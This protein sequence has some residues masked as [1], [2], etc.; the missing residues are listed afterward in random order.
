MLQHL[1]ESCFFSS[2]W[3]ILFYLR[4]IKKSQQNKTKNHHPNRTNSWVFVF[5]IRSIVMWGVTLLLAWKVVKDTVCVQAEGGIYICFILSFFYAIKIW[6]WVCKIKY[7]LIALCEA[8][9]E[10]SQFE[11]LQACYEAK[12]L[13]LLFG[14]FLLLL[15]LWVC[16][17]GFLCWF[18]KY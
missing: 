6:L 13:W 15:G 14:L 11:L 16:L 18:F 2:V 10:N 12:L 9:M 5:F 3:V 17:F 4:V 7:V 1:W 8:I